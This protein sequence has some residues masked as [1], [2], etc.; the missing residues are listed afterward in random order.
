[1][2]RPLASS[3]RVTP[4]QHMVHIVKQDAIVYDILIINIKEQITLA[5]VEQFTAL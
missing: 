4:F 3:H 1:M 5:I 2:Y